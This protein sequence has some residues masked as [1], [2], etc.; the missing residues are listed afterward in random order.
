MSN[1]TKSTDFAAKDSLPSG[2]S[3]KIIR[4]SEF[5]VEFDN[6][7]KAIATKVDS[8]NLAF[9]ETSVKDFGAVGDGVTD[10]TSAI[11]AAVNSGADWIYFPSGT[12]LVSSA[13]TIAS[14]IKITGIKNDSIIR[15][16]QDLEKTIIITADNVVIDGMSFTSTE[17]TSSWYFAPSAYRTTRKSFIYGDN[18]DLGTL[19]NLKFSGKRQGIRLSY[20]SKWTVQDIVY[21][22]F[23]GSIMQSV[24]A[25]AS[26]TTFPY[27]FIAYDAS[28]L[29]VSVDG[30]LKTIGVDYTATGIGTEN[31]GVIIFNT[32]LTGGEDVLIRAE[33]DDN[34]VTAVQVDAEGEHVISNLEGVYTGSVLLTG[35]ESSYNVCNNIKGREIHDNGIYNSSGNYNQYIGGNFNNTLGSG[36]KIRGS[37][38][39]VS[40]F[41][42]S[43]SNIGVTVTGNGSTPDSF[44]ANGFGNIV[45]GN[46]IVS[47]KQIGIL[48]DVQDGYYCRD[49]VIN[50][51]IIE[52]SKAPKVGSFT[53][54]RA[55][56]ARDLVI[57]DNIIRGYSTEF[58][59]FVF[60]SPGNELINAKISGNFIASDSSDPSLDGI[61]CHYCHESMITDNSGYGFTGQFIELRFCDKL[62][63]HGNNA[64]TEII[65][66]SYVA[67]GDE[68][69]TNLI[70]ANN[71]VAN[72]AITNGNDANGNPTGNKGYKEFPAY[73][74]GSFT[75]EL[76]SATG[77]FTSVTYGV[78]QAFYV[79][80][81]KCVHVEGV[82]E[83]DA[84]TVGTA[85]GDVYLTGLPLTHSNGGAGNVAAVTLARVN[86]FGVDEPSG[87]Y[88]DRNESQIRLEKRATSNG[89]TT[90][91]QVSDLG[92]GTNNNR[93]VFSAT[94]YVD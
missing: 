11:Q 59:M 90:P 86:S 15:D 30:S 87:G 14:K 92:T 70:V 17:T 93:M 19:S 80:N 46:T 5:E 78:Q 24:T 60:G 44:G 94:Y 83:T 18:C 10:D 34:F 65:N 54:I 75:I 36:I 27:T 38:N 8:S 20:C 41:S 57:S 37:A 56:V 82:L 91:L 22:G 3:G 42:I 32:P 45:S 76:A 61:R 26:Q 77:A 9:T 73:E 33:V 12:Y 7:A 67:S 6:I 29:S 1:Y 16:T 81:G 49:V 85:S 28:N 74:Y 39:L 21:I 13:I 89:A 4:G 47:H 23:L 62:F 79:R 2:D 53:S 68:T 51:N 48:V 55:R 40:N 64:R 72:V 71:D 66:A 63:I 69:N 88:I 43:N 84:I 35:F 58:G 31:G 25:S 52:A 50:G